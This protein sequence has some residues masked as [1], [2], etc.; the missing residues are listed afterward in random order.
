MRTLQAWRKRRY[1]GAFISKISDAEAEAEETRTWL[2]FAVHCG[3]M[4]KE[5]GRK[6]YKEYDLILRTLVGMIHYAQSWLL[7]PATSR[8]SQA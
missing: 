5:E 1:E 8:K 2:E 7:P 6:L 3:Y 4:Q